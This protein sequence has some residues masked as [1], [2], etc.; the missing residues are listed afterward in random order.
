MNEWFKKIIRD[1][2]TLGKWTLVQ[3]L[4]GFTIIAVIIG[5]VILLWDQRRPVRSALTTR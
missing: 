1:Q 5:S 4:I 2:G 3:K